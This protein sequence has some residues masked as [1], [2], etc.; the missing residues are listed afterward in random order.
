MSDDVLTEDTE[1]QVGGEPEASAE[2]RM[3]LTVDIENIGPCRK[4]VKVVVPRA[5]IEHF[6]DQAVAELREK[7]EVPGFRPGHV[8]EKLI[9]R[10][11]K[12]EIGDQIKQTVLVSSLE[13]LAE[14]HELDPINEPNLDVEDLEIPEEGDFEYQ[15]EVEVRPDFDL[16]DYTGLE[17]ERPVR[18]VT[19]DE[20][21]AFLEKYLAQYG[22]RREIDDPA[23]PGDFATAD[24]VFTHDGKELNSLTGVSLQLK[25]TLRF[26]DAELAGFDDLMKGVR[27][28]DVKTAQVTVS[29]ESEHIAMR[30]ETVDVSFTVK[31]VKRLEL[32]EINKELLERVGAESEG[33]LKDSI[34]EMLERQNAFHQRESTREQVLSKITESADW[35]LPEDL[36]LKQTENA[37]RRE[38]LEMQQAGFTRQQ[39]AARENE[40]RQKA[41]STTRQAL[42]EHFVLD[43]IA[44]KENIECEPGDV[45][46]EITMMALQRGESPRRVRAR[47][48][49]SGM[50]ENLEAQIRERKAVD[51]LL[52]TAS[53]KDVPA[54][55]QEEATAEA[56][57]ASVCSPSAATVE[58]AA[59]EPESD[60]D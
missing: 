1:E 15:F 40:I 20:V 37:L 44:T 2:Y 12:T 23:E 13:Q 45:D 46:M 48:Q 3:A 17:I 18:E 10:R 8:P 47:M 24:V 33:A 57:N 41:V 39:I 9:Q 42:K 30:G 43:K 27:P 56:V 34:R 60:A 49:K 51:F 59:E 29:P 22:E 28:G 36:V 54:P 26:Q 21:D 53:F 32:P 6:Q 14:E 25:P 31:A 50:L 19:D 4:K 35:D 11:F 55:A 58:V 16:P 52:S 38:M 7:A 5:D